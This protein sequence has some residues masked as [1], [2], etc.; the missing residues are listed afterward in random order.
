MKAAQRKGLEERDGG[1]ER[2]GEGERV[3]EGEGEGEGEGSRREKEEV[4]SP[5]LAPLTR[6][7]Y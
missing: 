2:G 5:S 7:K 4:I 1:R 6:K 3:G